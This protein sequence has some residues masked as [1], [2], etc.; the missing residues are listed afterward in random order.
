MPE[1]DDWPSFAQELGRKT[2]EQ[3]EKWSRAFEAGKITWLAY[4]VLV[5]G[6]YD[7]TSGI[8]PKDVSDLLADIHRDLRKK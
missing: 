8:I 6:L 4:Y 2:T 7:A 1:T 5:S 3:L